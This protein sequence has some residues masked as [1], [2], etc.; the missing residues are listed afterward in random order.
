[1]PALRGHKVLDLIM[2]VWVYLDLCVCVCVCVWERERERERDRERQR[3]RVYVC[4]MSSWISWRQLD[5]FVL[6]AVHASTRAHVSWVV[7]VISPF[8]YSRMCSAGGEER[9]DNPA[10]TV[11]HCFVLWASLNV[12]WS[13]HYSPSLSFFLSFFLSLALKQWSLRDAHCVCLQ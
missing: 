9:T 11:K 1:M 10:V 5:A 12:S 6:L 8:M 4:M 13:F 2:C 7:S 3:D